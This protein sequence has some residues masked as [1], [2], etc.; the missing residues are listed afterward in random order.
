MEDAVNLI[1]S[2]AIT[3][4]IQSG[5][6]Q[7]FV[8]IQHFW[9]LIP[10]FLLQFFIFFAVHNRKSTSTDW[11]KGRNKKQ[12]LYHIIS[13]HITS[14]YIISHHI[15]WHHIILCIHT[16]MYAYSTFHKIHAHGLAA[17]CFVVVISLSSVD[18]CYL[19]IFPRVTSLALGQSIPMQ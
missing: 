12:I 18:S 4:P 2:S 5:L 10:V 13:H 16:S 11:T 6:S 17:L 9:Q 1:K 19:P 15:L 8:E 7:S 14:Y 3:K